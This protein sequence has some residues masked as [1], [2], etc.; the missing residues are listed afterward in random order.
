[1]EGNGNI[2]FYQAE[3]GA[4]QIEVKL[5]N[6]TIWLTL[7]QMASLF[8]KDKSVISR[9]LS[10]VYRE[11]ELYRESTVAKNATVQNEGGREISR[12]ID[13]YNL[14]AVLSVGYRVNSIR[15]TQFRIWANQILKEYLVK[16]YTIDKKRFLDQ[17]R[18][19]EELKQTVK[20]LGNVIESKALNSEE[21]TG[22]LKVVTDYAYALDILDKYDHQELEIG[23]TTKEELFQITYADGIKA[24]RGLKDKFGGST[25]FGNEKDESFQGSLA[26]IYQ[27]FGGKDRVEHSSTGRRP[28]NRNFAIG[29]NSQ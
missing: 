27:T 23:S 24:I 22:L 29:L 12:D 16:G 17:S 8:G 1:M 19:L 5:E 25:L 20:L 9:H 6:E 11:G 10:N 15:G 21:A 28:I 14:D 4:T 26:A 7:N 13:Y 3:S 2:I 18:Q